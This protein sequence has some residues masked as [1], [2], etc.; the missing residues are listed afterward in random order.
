MSDRQKE[1]GAGRPARAMGQFSAGVE[2]QEASTTIVGGQPRQRRQHDVQIPVGVERAMV[3]AAREEGFLA[4]LLARRDLAVRERGLRLRGAEAAM[5]RLASEEQ[6]RALIRGLDLSPDN[7]QRRTF[8]QAVA[9]T[10]L[11]AAGVGAA[12]CSDDGE[13]KLDGRT[14]GLLVDAGIG[15]DSTGIRPDEFPPPSDGEPG[16]TLAAPDAPVMA[17]DAGIRAD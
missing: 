15:L 3:L 10:T 11:V 16:D 2:Q 14:D 13:V 12:G 17:P 1:R 8:L 5:L 7:L 6:L 4:D 9:A